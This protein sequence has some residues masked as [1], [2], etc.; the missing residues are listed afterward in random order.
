MKTLLAKEILKDPDSLYDAVPFKYTMT[1]GEIEWYWFVIDR[2]CIAEWIK[3]NS[4]GDFTLII[5][6]ESIDTMS[7]A[8]DD[9]QMYPKAV[10][11]SDDT[12]LQ[13]IFFYL[14]NGE[15]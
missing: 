14:Y 2:Y 11:L 12:A 9:D 7:A 10:M 15:N 3:N 1:E 5:D 6:D 8:L 4:D 13:H